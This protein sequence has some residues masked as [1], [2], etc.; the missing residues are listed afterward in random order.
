MLLRLTARHPV[1]AAKMLGWRGPSSPEPLHFTEAPVVARLQSLL[2]HGAV[3]LASAA[4][5]IVAA[6]AH[7]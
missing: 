2:G 7:R 6:G 3:A 1:R 5:L 4:A